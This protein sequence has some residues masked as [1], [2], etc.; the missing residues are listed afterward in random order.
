[1]KAC[2]YLLSF[3]LLLACVIVSIPAYCQQW[4]DKSNT[5]TRKTRDASVVAE[6][7][8]KRSSGNVVASEL[9]LTPSP[10]V[11]PSSPASL[12]DAVAHHSAVISTVEVHDL[13]RLATVAQ[14]HAGGQEIIETAGAFG[15]VSRFLHL[16][17]GV[18]SQNDM[19]NDLFVRGG[20]PMENLF[21]VDG[22]QVPNLNSLATL[23][24]TGGF[25]SMIDSAAI[26]SVSLFTGAYE[27]QYPGRLSSVIE[28]QTLDPRQLA[29]HAE[30]DFG[31]QGLGGLLDKQVHGGD[32]LV[33]VHHGLLNLLDQLGIGELPSYTNGLVR[34]RKNNDRGDRLTFLYLGGRDAIKFNPCPGD[35][36][37]TST[38]NSQYSGWRQTAG[39]EWQ[40][41]YSKNA[42]GVVNVSDSEQVDQIDQQ[43]QLPVPRDLPPTPKTCEI[44][45]S[46]PQPKPV[47]MEHSNNA[48]TTAGYRVEWSRSRFTLAAGSAFWLHRPHYRINQPLGAFSPYSTAP[49]RS[50]STS[51]VSNFSTGESGTYAVVTLRPFRSLSLS[52]AGRFQ[53]FALGDRNTLS[54]LISMRYHLGEYLEFHAA[55][56]TYEQMPPYV[57]LLSFPQNR[58]LL[59]MRATHEIAGID[60]GPV[61]ASQ[62]HIEA[63]NKIYRD[64]PA[65]TEFPNV[66]LHDLVDTLGQQ[67]VWLPMNS[68]GRGNSS[69]IEISDVTRIGSSLLARGSI[70]YSRAKFAGL[71]GI[72]R[73]SNFDLPWIANFAALQR[74]GHGYEISARFAYT[75]GRPYTPMDVHQSLLQNRAIYEAA[76]M[77]SRRAP[78]Y[79]RL[80]AQLNKD[81]LLHGMHM[82]LYLGVNNV[83]N[84]N[85]FL[86]Y[87]WLPRAK[88]GGGLD[89][90]HEIDQMPIFPNFGLRYIFR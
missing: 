21:L 64:V 19:T 58:S 63:Y 68:G 55:L 49:T 15:D 47:Y 27:V 28:I 75:T 65:S 43:D 22:I 62:I 60:I 85:N 17:P 82:E 1:M 24:T 11:G 4:N 71:D 79:A 53:S 86:G 54:P 9:D 36:L 34:F 80:D 52:A 7:Q 33:S 73:P 90:V 87:V 12:F 6:I 25:G 35:G 14:I 45:P 29:S 46:A 30:A 81:F 59:P 89:P 56:A 78:F 39:L 51:F 84:R 72:L 61:L 66:N 48:F 41:V 69:G 40:H 38:I 20:D 18:V 16:A 74:L 23:R 83:L 67:I 13:P 2:W 32:L 8:P 26:Q 42:F 5:E 88:P 31:I 76:N 50:D 70:A 44:P 3:S 10:A 77:N 37:E 57:Y